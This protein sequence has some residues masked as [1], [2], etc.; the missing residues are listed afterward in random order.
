LKHLTSSFY[1][2][3]AALLRASATLED[4][5]LLI[6]DP[7]FFGLKPPPD[8]DGAFKKR[9]S[10]ISPAVPEERPQASSQA[11]IVLLNNRDYIYLL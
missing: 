5:M 7:N 2:Q 9:I 3:P 10:Q 6:S 1:I 4:N 11:N 8:Q